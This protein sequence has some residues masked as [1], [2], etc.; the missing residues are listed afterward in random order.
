MAY[1]EKV[2]VVGSA[3]TASAATY[4]TAPT[5]IIKA[6][7]KEI[8]LCNTSANPETV[9][10]YVIPSA[11]SAAVA[12]TELNAVTLQPNETKIFGRTRVMNV[13]DFIQ[14]KAS[15]NAVVSM[16]VSGVERT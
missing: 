1:N 6:I 8:V 13:G 9:T 7:I 16:N 2:F 15:T 4:Y 3:L 14:A 5:T 10:F 12:N 11:G